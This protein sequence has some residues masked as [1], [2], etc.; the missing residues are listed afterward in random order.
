MTFF[1]GVKILFAKAWPKVRWLI[2]IAIAI[3]MAEFVAIDVGLMFAADILLYVELIVGAWALAVVGRLMPGLSTIFLLLSGRMF[4]F[5][6]QK[7]SSDLDDD[8]L[9]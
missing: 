2:L 6:M 4:D 3:S 8:H 5:G 7:K 9:R 1:R